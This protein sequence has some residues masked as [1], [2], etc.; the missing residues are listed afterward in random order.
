[1]DR[2]SGNNNSKDKNLNETIQSAEAR[3]ELERL[4][5]KSIEKISAQDVQTDLDAL[6]QRRK[7]EREK[8]RENYY[9][10]REERKR[11]TQKRKEK[12]AA[13]EAAAKIKKEEKEKKKAQL[14]EKRKARKSAKKNLNERRQA[15]DLAARSRI[16]EENKNV[17][18]EKPQPHRAEGDPSAVGEAAGAAVKKLGQAFAGLEAFVKEETGLRKRTSGPMP[19]GKPEKPAKKKSRLALFAEKEKGPQEEPVKRREGMFRRIGRF[20]RTIRKRR[21]RMKGREYY[22]A[23]KKRAVYRAIFNDC[24]APLS[25][26]WDDFLETSWYFLTRTGRDAWAIC[27][28]I[29]DMTVK[30]AFYLWSGILTVWDLVWD[31]RY[32][33]EANKTVFLKKFVLLVFS[34]AAIAIF[35]GSITAYEYSYYGKVLGIAKS[36]YEV[37]KTIEVLGDKLSEASGANVSLNVERDIEFRRIMGFNLD[38]DTDED[39]LNTLTYMKDLQVRAYG[40]FIDDNMVV[41][42]ENESAASELLKNIQNAYAGDRQ[43]VIYDSISFGEKITVQ[44]VGV[45]LGE[46]WNQKDAQHY[47]MT[48][49]KVERKHVVAQGETFGQI[50]KKYGLTSEELAASNPGINRDKIYIG[51]QLSLTH[52]APLVTVHSTETATYYERIDYGTQYIDNAS[53]YQGETEVK[54]RGV[55]GQNQIVA[56]VIRS[57]GV[58]ISRK[59]LT[60][61][62]LSD[63]V[64]EVLY[65]GTKPIPPKEGT[66]IFA[67][68]IRTYTITSRFGTRWGRMHTGVDFGSSTGTK[69]YASDGGTVTFSGWKGSYGY[70]IIINHGSLYE[71]YYAHC[72]KLLVSAGEKVYQGQNIAL[73]GSTGNSTGPHLHFEIRYHDKPKNPL[74]YL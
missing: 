38:I 32:W 9:K 72:S 22:T 68:P 55:Y 40:V 46:I 3:M 2:D 66:G 60:A 27:L 24:F 58:E 33:I 70:V 57:N 30:A 74:D 20:W 67:Y 47:L 63:P 6:L 44:E 15:R 11:S 17:R 64:D 23:E 56:Q 42:L 61:D 41:V 48:G 50:A 34:A 39:I 21:D 7:E 29:S 10:T 37:Y 5:K 13:A 59:I 12:M 52:G 4:L 62:K 1:M 65:R 71:T 45:Q 73:V 8:E 18:R 54:S 35:F 69:I 36:E 28:F 53:I 49:S 51:Q 16:E 25:D 26:A 31:V 19:G 43:G 14:Q